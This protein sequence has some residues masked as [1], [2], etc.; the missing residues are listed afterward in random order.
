MNNKQ[1]R[2]HVFALNTHEHD[3]SAATYSVELSSEATLTECIEAF[4]H[5]LN[6][7]GYMLPIGATLG[8]EYEEEFAETVEDPHERN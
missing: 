2:Q 4:G 1:K 8:L 5:F 3:K 7:A 6:S